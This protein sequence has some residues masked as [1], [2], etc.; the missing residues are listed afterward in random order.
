MTYYHHTYI[1]AFLPFLGHLVW[2]F[3][4]EYHYNIM[5]DDDKSI[6]IRVL[7]DLIEDLDEFLIS[8]KGKRFTSRP[9]FIKE[10][11]R[12]LLKE[13]EKNDRKH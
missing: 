10:A 4:L 1:N 13:Y 2:I 12:R 11:I 5:E 9:E 6:T 7:R 3:I 8:D